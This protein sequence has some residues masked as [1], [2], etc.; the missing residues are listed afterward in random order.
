MKW[1][2]RRPFREIKFNYNSKRAYHWDGRG[3]KSG[4]HDT[5]GKIEQQVEL[6]KSLNGTERGVRRV[7]VPVSIQ[8]PSQ[9]LYKNLS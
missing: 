9:M 8:H 7:N 2:T 4:N 6:C 3:V 1:Y 5:L